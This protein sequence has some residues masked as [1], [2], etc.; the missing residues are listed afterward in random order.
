MGKTLE[1]VYES[2]VIKPLKKL[3]LKEG[4]RIIVEIK[5]GLADVIDKYSRKV[6]R[7]VL[8]EFLED[9]R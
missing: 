9:R 3:E 5:E 2:G 6:N 4:T 8:K 1:A 7:D